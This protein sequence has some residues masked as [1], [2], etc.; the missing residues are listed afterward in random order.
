MKMALKIN[1]LC[2]PIA[3]FFIFFVCKL[4]SVG[5]QQYPEQFNQNPYTQNQQ[6][7][8]Q[9]ENY[10]Q[11]YL[12]NQIINQQ[13]SSNSWYPLATFVNQFGKVISQEESGISF[14]SIS[15][16][17]SNSGFGN[18]WAVG[19]PTD[20]QDDNNWKIYQLTKYGWKYMLDGK[21]VSAASDGT[22]VAID[23]NNN[24]LKFTKKGWMKIPGISLS[25]VSVG[26]KNLIW[27]ILEDNK[28][29]YKIF[30]YKNGI[31]EPVKNYEGRDS[32]GFTELRVNSYGTVFAI[33]EIGKV[34]YRNQ[35]RLKDFNKN[36]KNHL[37]LKQKQIQKIQRIQSNL[38]QLRSIPNKN[39][40]IK[41]TIRK[42]KKELKKTKKLAGSLSQQD[43]LAQKIQSLR[44]YIKRLKM[45]PYKTKR[46]KRMLKKLR[47]KIKRLNKNFKKE[48]K[49]K[50][51]KKKK[52]IKPLRKRIRELKKQ[53]N[54]AK[55]NEKQKLKN[56]LNK[57]RKKLRKIQGKRN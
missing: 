50:S 17:G 9:S 42:L 21:D 18:V 56:K 29:T 51:N 10:N 47:K 48:N 5:Y 22:V 20:N 8:D 38:H 16:G 23:N 36:Q 57:L 37:K 34:F 3:F 12:E 45:N 43:R 35:E 2:W 13:N 7:F 55:E 53:I 33:D 40:K 46:Q 25:R 1:L 11:S 26:N 52:K 19:E 6:F 32:K 44:Q 24:V 14:V 49:K 30:W 54:N 15:S 28:G 39:K 4:S 31:W 41:K 27:G